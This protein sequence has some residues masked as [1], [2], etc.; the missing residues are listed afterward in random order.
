MFFLPSKRVYWEGKE[1]EIINFF[2]GF[3][4]DLDE[5]LSLIGGDWEIKKQNIGNEGDL[6]NWNLRRDEKSRVV[7]GQRGDLRFEIREFLAG[8]S[9]PRLLYFYH[10]LNRGRL[11]VLKLGLN[12]PPKK[13]G[14]FSLSFLKNYRRVSWE[15]IEKI[16]SDEN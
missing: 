11:K 13:S 6:E 12:R 9:F 3:R 15:E 5:M 10:P 7:A 8:S 2:L 14:V 4:L 1:E 16:L